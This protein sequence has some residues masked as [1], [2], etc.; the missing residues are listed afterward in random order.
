MIGA[1]DIGGTKIAVA[2]VTRE[3]R[4]LCGE[5]CPTEPARGFDEACRRMIDMLE[6][7]VVRSR[8][9]LE[10]IGVGCTGPVDPIGGKVG[11]VPFLPGWEGGPLAERLSAAFQVE[12]VLENDADAHALA[13]YDWGAGRGSRRFIMVTVGTGIGGAMICDGNLYRGADGIH[14][15]FGH[16]VID[17]AGPICPCGV[18]GCW[19]GL[20]SGPA[21]A[22]RFA[23]RNP[24]R[25][26]MTAKEICEAAEQG[27]PQAREMVD[28]V[29]DSL[30]LGLANL[31]N[32]F[33]PD[34]IALG[35]GL[36]R[37]RHL[38]LDRVEAMIASH[39]RLVPAGTAR[40][41]PAGLGADAG[42]C[43]AACVWLHRVDGR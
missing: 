13:E 32:I 39:V 19:E 12:A 17:P 42:L 11:D 22:A 38:F 15:E 34:R 14:P 28:A 25:A 36:M 37:S 30:G 10:G 9:P 4:V 27:D 6:R 20:A 2:A 35:G 33:A 5:A 3:G 16:H 43:G 40:L 24:G 41:V 29:A 18:Q 21:L 7:C 31:V 23:A 26:A 8:E 1:I